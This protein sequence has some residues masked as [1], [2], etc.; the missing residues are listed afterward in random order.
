MVSNI[1]LHPYTTVSFPGVFKGT[2]FDRYPFLLPMM[3]SAT[4]TSIGGI[5]VRR[6]KLDPC[7]KVTGF[8]V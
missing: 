6:C 2:L 4:L 3:V 1:N 7:L 8:K 5:L